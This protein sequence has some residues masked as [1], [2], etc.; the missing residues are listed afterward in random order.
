MRGGKVTLT[1]SPVKAAA[2]RDCMRLAS[3][4]KRFKHSFLPLTPGVRVPPSV[5]RIAGAPTELSYGLS[6]MGYQENSSVTHVQG[7][8]RTL[9]H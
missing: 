9:N 3:V 2:F 6:A 1:K 8:L 4:H 7:G 5:A